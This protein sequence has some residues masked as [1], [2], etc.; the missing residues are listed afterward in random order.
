MKFSI[1]PDSSL[2]D[3]MEFAPTTV[4]RNG[5]V[6]LGCFNRRHLCDIPSEPR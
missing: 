5:L 6:V 2:L 3:I 1:S 4:E